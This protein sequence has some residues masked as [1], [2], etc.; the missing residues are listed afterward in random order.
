[1]NPS[2]RRIRATSAFIR[3]A[4]TLTV[5]CRAPAALRTRV[6]RSATGSFGVPSVFGRAFFGGAGLRAARS[7][8][9]AP[10]V[11]GSMVATCMSSVTTRSPS[12]SPAGLRHAR[13]LADERALA[14]A[15]P[16]E[17]EL[18][19]EAARSAADLTTMVGLNL[20][21]RRA[22]WLQDEALLCHLQPLTMRFG[23]ASRARATERD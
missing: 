15:D 13:K 9:G 4:G 14:E 10:S 16:A 22:L 6:S 2:S 11:A 7:G 19:H 17:A 23:T 20:E 8:L 5:S 1:M 3:L 18:P 21:L 12:R